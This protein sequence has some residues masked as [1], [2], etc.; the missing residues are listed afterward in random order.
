[1]ANLSWGCYAFS[2]HKTMWKVV[3]GQ[4]DI[5][6]LL[7]PSYISHVSTGTVRSHSTLYRMYNMKSLNICIL[8]TQD[9]VK[10]HWILLLF[11]C[12]CFSYDQTWITHALWNYLNWNPPNVQFSILLFLQWSRHQMMCS[13]GHFHDC[14]VLIIKSVMDVQTYCKMIRYDVT[15]TWFNYMHDTGFFVVISKYC[16]DQY[17]CD[18]EMLFLFAWKKKC[19]VKK[20]I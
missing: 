12:V 6:L 7:K 19:L 8:S 17:G 15:Q 20:I 11:Q 3:E 9:K 4:S 10:G 5:I 14:Q 18:S 13:E 2:V 16:M 1:M